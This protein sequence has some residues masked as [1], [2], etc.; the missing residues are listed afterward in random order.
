MV[1]RTNLDWIDLAASFIGV[2]EIPGPSSNKQIL[3]FLKGISS[4]EDTPWCAAFVNYVLS[5]T[6]HLGS[7]S[8]MAR[9][10]EKSKNF[11]HHTE[12]VPG[13]IVT[14]YRGNKAD[15]YGH[16]GFAVGQKKGF[17]AFLGGNQ[18]DSVSVSWQP[19]EFITGY[20]WPV[21]VPVVPLQ[22]IYQKELCAIAN[23]AT[24][25]V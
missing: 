7:G 12:Y 4:T 3:E 18:G 14:R 17:V 13:A 5:H 24:K 23:G 6:G 1:S 16:V 22:D 10:F 15:G 9:S 19:V 2:Q 20:H 8:A 11:I 21:G 25:M